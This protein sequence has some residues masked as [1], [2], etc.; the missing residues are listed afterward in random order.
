VGGRVFGGIMVGLFFHL[1]NRVFAN[2][3]LLQDW[4][5]VLA[6]VLP[7]LFFLGLALAMMAWVERR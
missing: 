7:T 1:L 3:G 2:L 6:A 4:P 5:P